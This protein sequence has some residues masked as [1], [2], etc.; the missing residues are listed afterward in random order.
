MP[1]G[2]TTAAPS[3]RRAGQ[4]AHNELHKQ[5]RG[6]S[7]L[8]VLRK[9]GENAAFLFTTEGRIREDNVYA[10]TVANFSDLDLKAIVRTDLRHFQPVQQQI[11]L[12][13][14]ERKWFGFTTENAVFLQ[15]LAV[16]DRLAL[17]FEMGR[18]P[19]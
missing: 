1:F 8:F 9:V 7:G 2:T 12:R 14:R 16:F 6:F 17:F 4:L 15:G 5:E 19:N 18:R 10:I 3:E 11:H 13:Q